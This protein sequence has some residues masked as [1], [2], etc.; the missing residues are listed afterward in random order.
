MLGS[1]GDVVV[2]CDVGVAVAMCVDGVVGVPVP[3]GLGPN[4]DITALVSDSASMAKVVAPGM[5]LAKDVV[6][7]VVL[8]ETAAVARAAT[9]ELTLQSWVV[10]M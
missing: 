7:A 2:A 6:I 5:A 4:R 8:V 1:R 9:V 3:A 10:Q